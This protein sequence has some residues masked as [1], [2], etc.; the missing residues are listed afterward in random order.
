[1]LSPQQQ[2][3]VEKLA[4]NTARSQGKI[5]RRHYE[6]TRE[7]ALQA[8][9]RLKLLVAGGMAG[10]GAIFG[11][12]MVQAHGLEGLKNV[13]YGLLL[14][15]K[16]VALGALAGGAGLG[17]LGAGIGGAAGLLGGGTLAGGVG[18]G[19]GIGAGIGAGAGLGA[20]TGAA[21]NRA[22]IGNNKLLLAAT[23]LGA[24][25]GGYAGHRATAP[26]KKRQESESSP[27]AAGSPAGG[28]PQLKFAGELA[29][30]PAQSE[31][32]SKL[33]AA[34]PY[35]AA[36]AGTTGLGALVG[37]GHQG[38]VE[39]LSPNP[40]DEQKKWSRRNSWLLG[41]GSGLGVGLSAVARDLWSQ[42]LAQ[43]AQAGAAGASPA[44]GAT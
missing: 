24:A 11:K 13:P 34:A 40:D 37:R 18:R 10:G 2:Q 14:H 3:F 23:L 38:L 42:R 26:S 12:P 25:G 1:M 6:P 44:T 22:G 35:A 30:T 41:A 21:M 43:E 32:K 15:P 19:A 20:A 39:L 33:M 36:L 8:E 17:A 7:E 31:L 28:Y 27:A 9:A 16:H 4:T 29:S 5:P